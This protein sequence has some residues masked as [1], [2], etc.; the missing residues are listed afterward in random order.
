VT[1]PVVRLIGYARV[2]L[3]AGQ[4]RRVTFAVPADLTCFTGRAGTRVVEPGDIE[5]RLSASSDDVRHTVPARLTGAL[6]EVGHHRRIVAD[7]S[8]ADA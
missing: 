2:A 1:R 4:A 8:L 7:V 5:L 3:E 6:R